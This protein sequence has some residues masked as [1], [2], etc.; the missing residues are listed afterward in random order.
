MCLIF[1]GGAKGDPESAVKSLPP[2]M[3]LSNPAFILR[4]A[5]PSTCPARPSGWPGWACGRRCPS[6]KDSSSDHTKGPKYVERESRPPFDRRGRPFSVRL[7]AVRYVNCAQSEERQNVEA[8]QF[9]GKVYYKIYKEIKP[10]CEMLV[11]YGDDYARQLGIE[12]R[13][14]RQCTEVTQ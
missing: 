5:P 8:L 12:T 6:Q 13:R 1:K 7:V 9:Q 3:S 14:R 4:G 2:F 11:W 10:F